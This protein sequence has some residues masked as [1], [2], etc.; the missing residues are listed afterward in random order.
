MSFLGV[1][2]ATG[3][4]GVTSNPFGTAN[5][6]A[7]FDPALLSIPISFEV[8]H[9]TLKGPVNS[10]AQVFIDTTFY[11]NVQRGDVN[12]W[13]PSQT[14]HIQGGSSIFFYWNTAVAPAPFVTIWCRESPVF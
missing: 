6:T 9:M 8:D 1:R 11:S 2:Q 13:D 7:T 10:Q 12:D 4:V 14:F 5:W 3:R